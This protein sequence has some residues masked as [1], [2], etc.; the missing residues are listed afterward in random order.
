MMEGPVRFDDLIL[1]LF[2]LAAS[3]AMV[4]ARIGLRLF[5]ATPEPPADADALALWRLKRRWLIWSELSALPAFA[6]FAVWVGRVYGWAP[7]KV[8]ML[9]MVLGALGFAF[10]LDALQTLVRRRAGLNGGDDA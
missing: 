8:V 5:G 1:W 7:E 9:S 6:T 3:L 4:G 10:L 2:S